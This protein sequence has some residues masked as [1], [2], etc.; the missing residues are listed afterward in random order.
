MPIVYVGMT[1]D[2]LHHGHINILKEAAKYGKVVV[3]LLT[4]HAVAQHKRQ[5]YLD[6]ERRKQ[7]LEQLK[8]VHQVIAQ[9]Q[10]DYAPTLRQI[11]PDVMIHGDD[12]QHGN[13]RFM[14]ERAFATMAEWGGKI[15]EVAYTEGVSSRR[16][17]AQLQTLGTTADIRRASLRR[18]IDAKGLVRIVE[19]H[20]PLSALIIEQT[21]LEVEHKIRSF[22]GF[23][24]SSLTDSTLRGKPDTEAVDLSTR[25]KSVDDIFEITTKP[26]I[27]DADT[28]GQIE[29]F[30]LNVKSLERL[31]VSAVIIEDKT[32]LKKN[33]LFGNE[34]PQQQDTIENFSEKLSAASQAKMTED[35]MIIARI[36]SLI[37]DEGIENALNRAKAYAEAGADGIMIHS[38]QKTPDEIL[39]FCSKFRQFSK[40]LDLV[41][42]PT[43]YNSITDTE[44]MQA[45]ANISIHANHMLRSS[46]LAMQKT[47]SSILQH[48]RSL[49]ASELCL[50]IKEILN[51]IPG[52]K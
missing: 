31:G 13:Y 9:E 2:I 24:A 40:T 19:A 15:I 42:V 21:E 23:W 30:C 33:S 39:E 35:F 6:F 20:S 45:G 16:L 1:A 34:V 25:I 17:Q 29:H 52:T 38:R 18:L 7:V 51:L 10:W 4:D 41:V 26:L 11:K 49:E 50:S 27:F 28:G 5:P 8:P 47:A 36:E 22:D 12:W 43:S 44:L 3:G 32:G 48:D 46:Y 37:L 14:R